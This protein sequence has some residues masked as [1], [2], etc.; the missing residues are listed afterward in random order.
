MLPDPS[1]LYMSVI[2]EQTKGSYPGQRGRPL[3]KVHFSLGHAKSALLVRYSYD[4][5]VDAGQIYHLDNNEWVLL[6]DVKQGTK[7]GQMPWDLES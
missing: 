7:K 6:Y 3:H 1:K 5:G 4:H 2:G